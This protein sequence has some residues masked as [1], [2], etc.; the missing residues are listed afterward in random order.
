[1]ENMLQKIWEC[2][3][4]ILGKVRGA[5]EEGM[6]LGKCNLSPK[7]KKNQILFR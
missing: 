5:P 6:K 1:M 2:Y 4:G 3:V 7:E